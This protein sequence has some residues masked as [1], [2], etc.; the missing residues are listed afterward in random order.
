M[1]DYY[2]FLKA[3]YFL[4]ALPDS[5]I[6]RIEAVCRETRFAPGDV[7]FYEGDVGDLFYIILEG[8]VEVWKDYGEQRGDRLAICGAGCSFGELALIDDGPRS[9]TVVAGTSLRVLSIQ[10]DDFNR[11]I[12]GSAAISISIMKSVSNMVRKQTESFVRH[13]RLG[14]HRLQRTCTRLSREMEERKTLEARLQQARKMEAIGSLAGGIAHDVNNLLQGI[15]GNTSLILLETDPDS[16]EYQR[17]RNIEQYVEAGG[18]LTRRI[19]RFVKG[20]GAKVTSVDVNALLSQVADQFGRRKKGLHIRQAYDEDLFSVRANNGEIEQVVRE[21]CT[22]AWE[23]MPGGG[24]LTLETRNVIIDEAQALKMPLCP[25][26]H[27][28]ISFSDTGHG[29]DDAIRHRIFDP[30][31]TTKEMGNGSGLGLALVY[32]IVKNY[33]GAICL[34]DRKEEGATFNIYLP[35]LS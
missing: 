14:K 35:G 6:R 26:P 18:A 10:K 29:V 1:K 34:D 9:A 32:N 31:F 2:Q 7:I 20:A 4:D 33:G 21:L 13:L 30:F 25:G 23:S 17:L 8:N 27:V 28:C 22:N 12:S 16:S 19:L 15:Q 11:I 5:D 24:T 3:V